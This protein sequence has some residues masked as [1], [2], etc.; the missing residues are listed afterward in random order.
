[1]VR[2]A[3][4]NE[5]RTLSE[6][7]SAMLTVIYALVTM[8]GIVC[9]GGGSWYFLRRNHGILRPSSPLFLIIA[10]VG[11]LF[12]VLSVIFAAQNPTES[13]C[14]A[15]G[16]CLMIGVVMTFSS[17]F[18]KTYR[19]AVVFNNK[20]LHHTVVLTNATSL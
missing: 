10:N 6:I 7:S 4:C 15:A 3:E 8:S 12:C 17:L 18:L 11:G 20:A 9:L 16:W 14:S 2:G 5:V 19:I 13:L 1:M